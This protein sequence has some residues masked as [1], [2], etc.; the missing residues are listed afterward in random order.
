MINLFLNHVAFQI[1]RTKRKPKDKQNSIV[2]SYEVMDSVVCEQ[3][4]AHGLED[5]SNINVFLQFF[6]E[7]Y[8]ILGLLLEVNLTMYFKWYT[9]ITSAEVKIPLLLNIEE[10]LHRVAGFYFR[11]Q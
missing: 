6:S 10:L 11:V 1:I 8:N 3:V 5:I 2:S 4:G 7:G 9:T